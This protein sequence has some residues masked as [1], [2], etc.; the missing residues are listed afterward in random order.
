MLLNEVGENLD[1]TGD[2]SPR[3]GRIRGDLIDDSGNAFVR[4]E[5]LGD[6]V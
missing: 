6:I 4:G 1:I 2:G 5:G 3:E